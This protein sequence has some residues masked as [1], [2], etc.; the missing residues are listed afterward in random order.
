MKISIRHDSDFKKIFVT[1]LKFFT[2]QYK[3][4]P[5]EIE[6]IEKE[7]LRRL[8]D[9]IILS[10]L[11]SDPKYLY[12]DLTIDPH[13]INFTSG[14]RSDFNY[15]NASSAS[16]NGFWSLSINNEVDKIIELYGYDNLT[17]FDSD[18]L[19]WAV[20]ENEAVY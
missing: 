3:N 10:V 1:A 12:F 19:T 15:F 14:L 11:Y 20:S 6:N 7:K 5:K 17:I 9:I 8:L 2:I 18:L 13:S 16:N 4:D